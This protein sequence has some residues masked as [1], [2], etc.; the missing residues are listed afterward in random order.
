MLLVSSEGA[1]FKGDQLI[2]VFPALQVQGPVKHLGPRPSGEL[3]TPASVLQDRLGAGA[4][5]PSTESLSCS[6]LS[7]KAE[8]TP[9]L[10]L[11][12]AESVLHQPGGLPAAPVATSGALVRL[13]RRSGRQDSLLGL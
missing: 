10:C 12:K 2:S 1:P 9:P 4:L 8:R 5:L 6:R 7:P 3:V 13:Q 11:Q